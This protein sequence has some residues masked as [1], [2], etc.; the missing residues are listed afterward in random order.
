MRDELQTQNSRW[1]AVEVRLDKEVNAVRT[2]LEANKNDISTI[3]YHLHV[4]I[5]TYLINDIR[6]PGTRVQ[7][8]SSACSAL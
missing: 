2:S 1:T 4:Q 3:S 5:I 7:R 8:T 6:M